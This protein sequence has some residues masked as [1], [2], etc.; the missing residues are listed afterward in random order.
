MP[1]PTPGEIETE[2][3]ALKALAGKIRPYSSFGDDNNAK[4]AAQI[5][6][7]E[8]DMPEGAIYGY[9]ENSDDDEEDEEEEDNAELD[10]ALGARQ[11]LDGQ[12][13]EGPDCPSPSASWRSLVVG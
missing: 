7:I 2:L 12:W 6:V 8:T 11:W 9:Y 13:N 4:L 1:K 5:R 3:S 10:A